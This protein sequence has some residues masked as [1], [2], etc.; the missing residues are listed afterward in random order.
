MASLEPIVADL[1]TESDG[2]DALLRRLWIAQ[3]F[4]G[5]P[6]GS[7]Q[8]SSERETYEFTA[9]AAS[10]VPSPSVSMSLT[11]HRPSPSVST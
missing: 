1:R 6:G 5:P 7:R 11:S 3:A 10:A 8:M 2:L 9:L 4:A